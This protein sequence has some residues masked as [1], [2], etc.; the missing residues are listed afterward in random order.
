MI[1]LGALII[2][3]GTAPSAMAQSST[4][5]LTGQISDAQGAVIPGAAIKVVDPRTNELRETVTN[6]V[7][8]F[9]LT[10]VPA[11]DYV[12]TITKEGFTAARL[13]GQHVEVGEVLTLNVPLAIGAATTTVEVQAT[14]GAELQTL[15][16]TI[17]STMRNDALT[18]MPNLSRDVQTLAS[19]QV[20]VSLDGNVAGAAVDQNKTLLDGGN[21]SDDMSGG[22]NSYV[23]GTGYAGASA[24][25][26]APTGVLP[27]PVESIEEFKVAS[28]G[29][30]ADFGGA[31]GSS[32]QI[33]T[34]RGTNQYHG[35]AYEYYFANDVGAANL[36]KNNHTPDAFTHTPDTP[37]PATHRNRFGG[38]LG[39]P[40]LPKFLGGKTYFFANFE[41]MRYPYVTTDERASPTAA[42]R[43]GIILLPSTAGVITPYNI[44]TN[45]V[46]VGG[47]TY[48]GCNATAS[49]DPRSIGVNPLIQKIWATMP[50]P[51]DPSYTS[52]TPGDGY[53]NSGGFLAPIALPQ[54]SNFI[55]GRVDHDFGEKNRLMISTRV[56]DYNLL[57]SNQTD[58]SGLLGGPPGTYTATAPRQIKPSFA[59]VGLSTTISP[60]MTNDLHFSYTRNF[61]IWHDDAGLPQFSNLGGAVEI[62]GESINALIPYNVDSQDTRQRFWDGHDYYLTDQLSH[63]HGNHVFQ[64]GGTYQRN[65]D[66]HSRNDNGVTIDTSIT[67]LAASGAGISNSAYTLPSGASSGSLANF[68]GLFDQATGIL[69]QTQLAYTRSGAALNLN[70]PGEFA[71]DHSII[72]SY[73]LYWTDTWHIKPH[74]TLSYGVTWELSMPPYELS[75]KQVQMV[76]QAGNPIDIK[77]YLTNR[78]NQAL[79]GQVYEPEIGFALIGNA[80][81]GENKYPYKTFYG[82]FSPHMSLAY[83]PNFN[84]GLLSKVFG[85]NNTV[86]RGGYGRIYGRLNGVDLM[87]VPLLG[88][89]LIQ[90]VACVGPTMSGTCAGSSGATPTTAFRIGVDGNTAPLPQVTPTLPQPFFPGTL[91]NGVV[92]AGAADGSQLDPNLRPNHSDEFTFSL[93]RAIS[94]KVL[95]EAGYIGRVIHNEFQEINI[96]AVPWMTTVGGQSFAQAYAAVYTEYCGLQ[97]AT[98]SGVTCNKNAAAVTPQPFFEAAMGGASSA[99]CASAGSCTAAVVKAEGAN[100]ATTSVNTM[101]LDLGKSSSWTLGRSMLEQSLGTGLNQQLTGAFDFI[102]SYGHGSYNAAF[103]TLRTTNWHNIT[104]Q[105][106]L[107]WGRALG[108]GSVVQASSSITVPDPFDF[109]NFGTYGVQPFDVKVTYSLLMYYQTPWFKS[110]KGILGRVVGGWTIA[111]LFTARGGLPQRVAN[112]G[113]AQSFG[114]IYSGQ[115]ANYEEAAGAAPFTGGSSAAGFY[116]YQNGGTSVGSSGNPAK[117]GSG[118]SLFNNPAAVAAEFRPAVLGIDGESGGAGVL[119]G[120]PF[121]NLDATL[122]KDVGIWKEG[123]I[124]ATIVIQTVNLLNHFVPANPTTNI[125]STSSFGV[126]TAQYA[127]ANGIQSRWMEFGIKLRF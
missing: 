10:S 84:D 34:K 64:Y 57:V 113:D 125:Q 98:A 15:N 16:A 50:L 5:T 31:A 106:N 82:G 102:N 92:N 11:G 54:T 13:T 121:W 90:G 107:T 40:L 71:E 39:G 68:T 87:L 20:G 7:G 19:L 41:G 78:M 83:N 111:P 100:F 70:P 95:V 85:H 126:V 3:V 38:A 62:G 89:G 94:P 29:Q 43:A 21:N 122:Q 73:D 80:A 52:G 75:G 76:D 35:V 53:G 2:L 24:T 88:P 46:T 81:G 58:M 33:A 32:V 72:P 118:V 63:L 51:N 37:L 69:T 79:E 93:Q 60:N 112:G 77:G 27:T 6:E 59:V 91:Q 65:N 96:D 116:N 61:W 104:T 110:Q 26:G 117:G 1:L 45:P 108:T 36:W 127:S 109:K 99:Y 12:I 123:R 48:A 17:G 4:G 86:I 44:N 8:R 66:L 25:G 14:A 18:L 67:Y 97:G 30:T 22:S 115:S 114:E 119:R 9:T 56:Y 23:P 101:W 55:V 105:S 49:C 103:L 120:F 47:T 124:G 74:L 28:L 42:Y